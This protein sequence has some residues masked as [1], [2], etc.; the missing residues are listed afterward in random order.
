MDRTK[1]IKLIGAMILAG[2]IVLPVRFGFGQEATDS[3]GQEPRIQIVALSES[4]FLPYHG[5]Y[6]YFARELIRLG[7]VPLRENRIPGNWDIFVAQHTPRVPG[8]SSM[9]EIVVFAIR[10]KEG[11]SP[12]QLAKLGF[13]EHLD[14]T[15]A[16]PATARK[17][18]DFL[19]GQSE[20]A[21][22]DIQ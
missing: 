18:L 8:E 16:G 1:L 7:R 14:F 19:L 3:P 12:V 2:A 4:G 20:K 13:W 17:V 10:E 9:P 6:Q 5:F 15:E 21:T 22:A 11:A